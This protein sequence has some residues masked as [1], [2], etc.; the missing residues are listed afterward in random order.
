MVVL[1]TG[2]GKTNV[3]LMVAAA[4]LKQYPTSKV[5][6]VGPTRPLID[7]YFKAFEKHFEI[8]VD[9]MA[10]FTGKVPPAK[11]EELWKSSRIIFSTP[12]GLENDIVSNRINLEQVSLL[13]LDESHRAVGSY[14]YVWVAAQYLKR[15]P[16]PR[17]VGM[18]ASPGSDLEKITEVC[19]N[20]GIE[21]VEV[22]TSEDPDVKPYIFETKMEWIKLDLPELLQRIRGELVLCYKKKLLLIRQHGYLST[23]QLDMF[24][25][26]DLLMMQRA[27]QAEVVKGN[28]DGDSLKALSLLAEA[29]KVQH[30][31]ELVETQTVSALGSYMDRLQVDAVSTKVR[32]VKN[33]VQDPNFK[34]AFLLK[35]RAIEEKIEHPKLAKVREIVEQEFSSG[36][37]K[38]IVFNQYRETAAT[39]VALLENIPGVRASI[40]VGQARKNGTQVTQKQ[41]IEILDKFRAG[42]LNVLVMTSVGEEGLDIPSVDEVIFYEPIPSAIRT[43]QRR[44]RTGRHDEGRVRILVAKNTRD[45][46]FVWAARN[47]EKRMYRILEGLKKNLKFRSSKEPVEQKLSSFSEDKTDTDTVRIIVDYR[48]RASQVIKELVEKQVTIELTNLQVGDYLVSNRCVIEYKTRLDF[49]NSLVDGRL[50]DQLREL[51]RYY[52]RPLVILEGDTDLYSIR[53]VHPNAI[54]G[55][56]ATISVSYGIPILYTKNARES[57]AM[58]H[59]IARREQLEL[60]KEFSPHTS[61]KPMSLKESQEY[62]VG[63]LPSVGPSIARQLLEHFKSVKGVMNAS[64]YE[65][66]DIANIGEKKAKIIKEI[67]ESTY[68]TEKT[69]KH[70][71]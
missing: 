24:S 30:A 68:E 33:L 45:E 26:K 32:A 56:L 23:S 2:L 29:I 37:K 71:S 12:Q 22:R 63:A 7:Q 27:L 38:I 47:K 70:V 48:E 50:L 5:L 58:I 69:E 53:Q 55:L 44:G 19:K 61:K 54:L 35:E 62:V 20:L 40:F 4:R 39:I 16:Y 51:K 18:T 17:I 8:P 52:G 66:Q 59:M 57:A 28:R 65:L 6:L 34:S 11:R 41:Q 46:A 14:S 13:G 67:V 60:G 64:E 42:V 9:Q 36:E 25:K 3:F 15:A 21:N 31:L 1:P 10:I 43:I 49:V